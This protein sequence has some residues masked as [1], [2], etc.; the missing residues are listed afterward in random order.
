MD[1]QRTWAAEC[2]PTI[3]RFSH[4]D[5][6][7]LAEAHFRVTAVLRARKIGANITAGE[8]FWEGGA[9]PSYTV[10][11]LGDTHTHALIAAAI[12]GG[13]EAIQV[14]RPARIV[15]EEWRAN[16]EALTKNQDGGLIPEKYEGPPFI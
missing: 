5:P 15:A 3:V 12:S 2:S 16:E 13:C 8:G 4:E 11:L 10:E 1:L 6:A 9:E 7:T 14:E